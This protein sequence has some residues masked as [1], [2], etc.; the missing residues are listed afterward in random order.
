VRASRKASQKPS[1]NSAGLRRSSAVE[2]RIRAVE[3]ELKRA[4]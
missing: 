1:F 2:L 3:H 4:A